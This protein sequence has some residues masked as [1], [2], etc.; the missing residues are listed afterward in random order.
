MRFEFVKTISIAI[1]LIFFSGC[2]WKTDQYVLFNKN[3]NETQL[4][5]NTFRSSY[6]YKIIP[7]NRLSVLV[8]NHPELSTRDVRAAID[9]NNERGILIATDGTIDLP[10]IGVI[11]VAGLTLREASNLLSKEY[12]RYIKNA[13]VTLDILNKRVYVMGEVRT[14]GQI[15]ITGNTI[16]II[17]AIAQSGDFTDFALKNSIKIIRGSAKKPIVQS[18]DL[19]KINTLA[20][21]SLYLYPNDVVYVMPN[22]SRKRNLAI[23]ESVPGITVASQILTMLLTGKYLTETTLFNVTAP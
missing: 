18:V 17:E 10:L 15:P 23:A 5:N 6:E 7:D 14:P 21:N 20:S 13:H 1:L 9:P 8:Y 19:T 22:D 2:S 12:S 11:K 3:V 16:N 4:T